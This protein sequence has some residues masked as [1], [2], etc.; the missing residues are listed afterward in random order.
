MRRCD[1]PEAG[2]PGLRH[3]RRQAGKRAVGLVRDDERHAAALEAPPDP[4]DFAEAGMKAA[5]D[6]GFTR[7]F[8]GSMSND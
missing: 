2:R 7:L 1:D 6:P 3:P 8:A 4:H 5:G